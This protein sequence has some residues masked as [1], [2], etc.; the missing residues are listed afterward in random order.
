MRNRFCIAGS[1]LAV[2]SCSAFGA[3]LP[4]RRA[5]AVYT[6]PPPPVFTW[7]GF[8]A[9]A[10]VGAGFNDYTSYGETAT[11]V[12]G[13]DAEVL[14]GNR[15]SYLLT[16]SSSV[17]AGGQIGYNIQINQGLLG[18]VLNSFGSVLTPVTGVF[19]L[20]ASSG[21]VAGI[22]ADADYAGLRGATSFVGPAGFATAAESREHFLATVRGRLGYGFGNVLLFGTGGF[23]YGGV[24]DNLVYFNGAG[25]QTGIGGVNR[26]QTGY[27]Y[28]GGIEYAIPTSSF[29][30]V[31]RSNAVTLK[32]EY[33]HYVLENNVG[34]LV[35]SNG[36]AYTERVLS[37]GN[38]ARVGIN[39][40]FDFGRAAP[41][42]ARY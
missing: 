6:P 5:P 21:P 27:T 25:A 37:Y 34:T 42:V 1:M 26:I 17:V 3:D 30:N 29:L 28:G 19:G 35:N 4:S 39:Y 32:V 31:F 38:L 14:A 18:N 33:L 24:N 41:V 15:P 10:N 12:L 23:A 2:A 11:N 7:S 22:E 36:A 13:F 16:K 20:G 9:G 40:K 8:Y